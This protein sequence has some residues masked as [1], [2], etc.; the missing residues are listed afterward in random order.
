MTNRPRRKRYRLVILV[1]EQADQRIE[2]PWTYEKGEAERDLKVISA[3]QEGSGALV[4]LPWVVVR[5][6][7]IS[8]AHIEERWSSS[9]AG[10]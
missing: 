5:E 3:A 2:G 9:V 4:S 8:A 10:F 7:D 6:G 1:K